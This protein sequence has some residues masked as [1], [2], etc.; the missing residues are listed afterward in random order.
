MRATPNLFS[1]SSFRDLTIQMLHFI[2]R[3]FFARPR[4][5]ALLVRMTGLVGGKFRAKLDLRASASPW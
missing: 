2:G 4:N 1:I 5:P 3:G